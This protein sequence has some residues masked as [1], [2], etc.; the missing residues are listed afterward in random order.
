M[1]DNDDNKEQRAGLWLAGGAAGLAAAAVLFFSIWG[2]ETGK[3]EGS[4]AYGQAASA[5]V[6]ET[7]A[8]EAAVSAVEG[9]GLETAAPADVAP[10]EAVVAD[11]PADD[12]A[13]VVVENGIVK[14]YFASGKAD[15][16][17]GAQEALQ[18][19]LAGVKEGKKAIVS[20][21]HDETGNQAQNEELSKQR[22]LAVKNALMGFGVAEEQIELR[23]PA[24]SEGSGDNAEAR[25][26]EVVLE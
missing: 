3:I 6:S 24:D 26:V 25:R 18:D 10:S 17:E 7:A 1:S 4:P 22:A 11:A 23:K 5:E 15:L 14:F 8:E 21:Y 12:A 19:V 13:A 2:W 16:A 20:G 9:N